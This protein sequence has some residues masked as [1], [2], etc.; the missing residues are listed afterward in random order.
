MR[1]PSRHHCS[2]Q[3]P[4]HQ[5]GACM[6]QQAVITLLLP[7][8]SDP[9]LKHHCS[10]PLHMLWCV[11]HQRCWHTLHISYIPYIY[12]MP[13]APSQQTTSFTCGCSWLPPNVL[14]SQPAC[15]C[16]C[17]ISADHLNGMFTLYWHVVSYDD[18]APLPLLHCP[19]TSSIVPDTCLPPCLPLHC[20]QRLSAATTYPKQASDCVVLTGHIHT[21]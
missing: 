17:S 9:P 13:P 11:T 15:Q 10:V 21:Y 2:K 8:S 19:A 18:C 6:H 1:L 3:P 12:L 20:H 4:S 7:M 5:P 14:Y 16:I